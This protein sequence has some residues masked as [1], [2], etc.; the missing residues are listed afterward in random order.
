M[1]PFGETV[2]AWRRAAK[3]TQAALAARA[4]IPRPNLSS[5]ERGKRDVNLSTLRA[6]AVALGITPG[7]LVDGVPP[8]GATLPMSRSTMEEVAAAAANDQRLADPHLDQLAR[9]LREAASM[10][11]AVAASA[12]TS[13]R[14]AGRA[15]KAWFQLRTH[16]SPEILA[17][18]L[19]RMTARGGPS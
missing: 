9:W 10:R 14:N 7:V 2:L 11:L 3:L 15:E 18:L 6:L 12:P 19:E 4:G 1:L 13:K 16:L 8:S 5:I 17:S